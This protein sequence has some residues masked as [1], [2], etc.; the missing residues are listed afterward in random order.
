[1]PVITA[2]VAVATAVATSVAAAATAAVTA[3][4]IIAPTVISVSTAIGLG[5]LVVGGIGMAIGNED[6]MFAGK[7]MGYVGMAGAVFGGVAGGLGSV[8]NGTGTFMEGVGGAFAE[9]GKQFSGMW[10]K[11]SSWFSSGDKVTGA[12]S[13]QAASSPGTLAAGGKE[14]AQLPEVGSKALSLGD[15]S[16]ALTEPGLSSSG[17][18]PLNS[19]VNTAPAPSLSNVVAPTVTTPGAPTALGS[20]ALKNASSALYNVPASP[21]GGGLVS[22]AGE[23]LAGTP[24]WM[25][26][27]MMTTAGQGVTG[28]A[29]G[30][31]QGQSAEDQLAQLQLQQDR[32]QRQRELLNSQANQIP[33]LRFK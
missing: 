1:M 3:A 22:Q 18:N 12:I 29:G 17:V 27:S 24:D 16:K 30:Y 23:A 9:S 4:A 33:S 19:V 25:K 8:M 11:A 21:A 7:I 14:V 10:D 31:F 28:L 32:D 13:T 6:L 5:G 26:Y 20:E 2:A 15:A